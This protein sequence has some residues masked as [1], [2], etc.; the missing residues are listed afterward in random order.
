MIF[1]TGDSQGFPFIVAVAI[2]LVLGFE[3]EHHEWNEHQGSIPT[4]VRT[5]AIVAL[6][7]AVAAYL[8][9][10][11][12]AAGVIAVAALLA[13]GYWR[14]PPG[15]LGQ[16]TEFAS[17]VC[18]LLGALCQQDTRLAAGLAA[19]MAVLL[20]SKERI[21]RLLRDVVTPV[22]V[23][24][25][26]RWFALAFVVYPLIPDRPFGPEDAFNPSQTW[27]LLVIL[28]GIGWIGHI[29]TRAVGNRR[30]MLVAGAAGGF[31][32]GAATTASLAR[33]AK[34]NPAVA[35]AALAG[36][37]LA[38][39]ATCIQLIVMVSI[40][41][42]SLGEA[43]FG[44]MV[45]GAATLTAAALLVV[46]R[47]PAA[48]PTAEVQPVERRPLAMKAS[49]T[50][51]A[52]LTATLAV[53]TIFARQLGSNAVVASSAVVGFADAHSPA[54]A[55]ASLASDGVI[56]RSTAVQAV[57][58]GLATNTL[59]KITLAVAG[60]GWRFGLR[61]V[62]LLGLSAAIVG[63]ALWATIRATVTP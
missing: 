25:A 29:S 26:V 18:F 38:S 57:G 41:D 27:R 9:V 17:L 22:E 13:L 37:L 40:T 30:G 4:G 54:L 10:V 33:I 42:P 36:M 51:A 2:G 24:D 53:S 11:I 19:G 48:H 43:I 32:S 28:T 5:L 58:I 46:R 7:G 45:A 44:P 47:D 1:A 50:A 16:T 62:R 6:A 59:T 61:F 52:L 15:Q 63:I 56:T 20:E 23:E 31:V 34:Q 14:S 21:R 12:V 60:G 55:A 49:L 3:R 8:D 35:A 39:V